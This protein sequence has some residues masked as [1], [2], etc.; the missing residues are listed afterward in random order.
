MPK[1]ILV[2]DDE[3]I[4]AEYVRRVMEDAGYLVHWVGDGGAALTY[5]ETEPV[6]LLVVDIILPV[7]GGLEVIQAAVRKKSRP[8]IIAISGGGMS[9]ER[10]P[11]L[12]VAKDL[13]ADTCMRKPFYPE[14]LRIAADALVGSATDE[15]TG[16]LLPD[17]A[18]RSSE[19]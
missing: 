13:G 4:V 17:D 1:L 6:D 14:D 15:T 16:D 8:R 18:V 19:D 2:V 10:D 7:V 3:P 9:T 12:V 5:L 11:L